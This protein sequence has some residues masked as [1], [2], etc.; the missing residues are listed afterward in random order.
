[1][2][3]KK[4]LKTNGNVKIYYDWEWSKA[5]LQY[6]TIDVIGF[7]WNGTNNSGQPLNVRIDSGSNVSYHKIGYENNI[8]GS[9]TETSA[10]TVDDFYHSA[11]AKFS[12]GYRYEDMIE[13]GKWGSGYISLNA[14]GTDA[15]KEVAMKISYGHSYITLTSPSVSFHPLTLGISF[16][17]GV[18]TMATVNSIYY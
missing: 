8:L 17:R 3:A 13:F 2:Y 9:R 6:D 7:V 15:I 11:Y 5:P 18:E 4:H 14:S 12:L 10:L 1:L 16:S